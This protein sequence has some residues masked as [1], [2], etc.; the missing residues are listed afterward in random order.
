MTTKEAFV[1]LLD[2]PELLER[3]N[4]NHNT[5]RTIK[6]RIRDNR[7]FSINKMEEYLTDAGATKKPEAWK[8]P[9]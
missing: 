4:M 6:K 5:A 9:K 1:K 7:V 2:S 8:F 3:I